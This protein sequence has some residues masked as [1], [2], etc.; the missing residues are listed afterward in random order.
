VDLTRTGGVVGLVSF[1]AQP[2][3]IN[4]ARWLAKEITVVASNA[5]THADFHRSMGFL[6]DGRVRAKPL[7][8]RTVGLDDLESALRDLAT[9]ATDDIKILVDPAASATR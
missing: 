8:T 2:A 4:G 3:T 6:A 1:L 5:F 9:V 7:H